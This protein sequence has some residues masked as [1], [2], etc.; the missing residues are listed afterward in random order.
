MKATNGAVVAAGSIAEELPPGEN[1][2]KSQVAPDSSVEQIHGTSA[3]EVPAGGTRWASGV[4]VSRHPT[5]G[6]S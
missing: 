2:E 5:A 1:S 3:V 4:V 6:R